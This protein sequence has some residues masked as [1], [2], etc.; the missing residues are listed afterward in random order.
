MP[1]G[2]RLRNRKCPRAG[3]RCGDGDALHVFGGYEYLLLLLNA[4]ARH[5][6][7]ARWYVSPSARISAVCLSGW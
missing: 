2:D 7:M 5:A 3:R 1:R 4:A 6:S